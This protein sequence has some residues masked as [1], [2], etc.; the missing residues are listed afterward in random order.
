MASL[1]GRTWNI[2][3]YG[4]LIIN[5]AFA[6]RKRRPGANSNSCWSRSLGQFRDSVNAEQ[7][8][9]DES[10]GQSKIAEKYR[11]VADE[12]WAILFKPSS[13]IVKPQPANRLRT[14]DRTRACPP[15]PP[16]LGSWT[17]RPPNPPI[18]LQQ[19]SSSGAIDKRRNPTLD[20]THAVPQCGQ[21]PHLQ[22]AC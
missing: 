5:L 12:L 8:R 10:V 20:S 14:S 9:M 15:N 6:N 11:K 16:F 1:K 19:P 17:S 7:A 18:E 22:I 3:V 21:T 4:L 13:S 2:E